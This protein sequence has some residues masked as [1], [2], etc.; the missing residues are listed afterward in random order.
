MLKRKFCTV[1]EL[2]KGEQSRFVGNES[3]TVVAMMFPDGRLTSAT[4]GS[5]GQRERER[6]AAGA[7]DFCHHS[8]SL[9]SNSVVH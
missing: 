5:D 3:P 6:S 8:N 1:T 4:S 9:R 2:R 7:A